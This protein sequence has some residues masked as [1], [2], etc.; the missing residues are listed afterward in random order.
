VVVLLVLLKLL[1]WVT[2]FFPNWLLIILVAEIIAI[3]PF[4]E[5]S[6]GKLI[7][8]FN[9]LKEKLEAS[10]MRVYRIIPRYTKPIV[11]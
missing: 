6:E 11:P 8:N 7:G 10:I 5:P 3:K 1:S 9:R 2:Y 4:L